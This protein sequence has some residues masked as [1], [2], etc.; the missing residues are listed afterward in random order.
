MRNVLQYFGFLLLI[1]MIALSNCDVINST[2][3]STKNIS[4]IV[5]FNCGDNLMEKHSENFHLFLI[6]FLE[7][8]TETECYDSSNWQ[9]FNK[10]SSCCL[11][12]TNF[13]SIRNRFFKKTVNLLHNDSSVKLILTNNKETNTVLNQT[14]FRKFNKINELFIINNYNLTNLNHHTLTYLPKLQV[15][16]LSNN[17][18]KELP[19]K[20]FQNTLN[21]TTIVIN[22]N[23]IK[24]FRPYTFRN[25]EKLKILVLSRNKLENIDPHLFEHLA[26]LII[27]NL[28]NNHLTKLSSQ[29]F[30]TLNNIENLSFAGNKLENLPKDI[31]VGLKKLVVLSMKNNRFKSL[32]ND[33]WSDLNVLKTLNIGHNRFENISGYVNYLLYF[34]RVFL[35]MA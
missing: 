30:F 4:E 33:I 32:P 20:I 19:E 14:I 28:D 16:D 26:S 5:E 29:I 15:I 34:L 17:N 6:K 11:K 2:K 35:E 7:N 25:L 9:S 21:L 13:F 27:L 18:L 31:F 1:K 22:R 23:L 8:H 24:R 12:E 10:N 3:C